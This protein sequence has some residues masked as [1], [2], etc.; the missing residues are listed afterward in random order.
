MITEKKKISIFKKNLSQCHFVSS[1][2]Q[3]MLGVNPNSVAIFTDHAGSE[4]ELRG[5]LYIPCWE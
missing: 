2:L 5:D 3:T 1:P 4:T